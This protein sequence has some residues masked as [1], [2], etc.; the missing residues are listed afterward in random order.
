MYLISENDKKLL[1][2]I[3]MPP[4][5]PLQNN[6]SA[7]FDKQNIPSFHSPD[8]AASY[9]SVDNISRQSMPSY[10]SPIATPAANNLS[11]ALD[12]HKSVENISRQSMP[13]YNTATDLFTNVPPPTPEQH[14]NN[15]TTTNSR[16]RRRWKRK[17]GKCKAELAKCREELQLCKINGWQSTIDGT[18]YS[19]QSDQSTYIN[20]PK[21]SFNRVITSTPAQHASST[22]R[23]Q[24][25]RKA[26]Q[27]FSPSGKKNLLRR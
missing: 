18:H 11:L 17:Q 9:S 26:P 12:A 4:P 10:N 2:E 5:T 7:S 14:L 13:S 19:K 22:R 24:R 20:T 23:Q 8:A 1:D 3:K 25:V 27:R 6:L 15:D 16:E 21:L